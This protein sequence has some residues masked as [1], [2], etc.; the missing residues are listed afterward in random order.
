MCRSCCIQVEIDLDMWKDYV[1]FARHSIST[2]IHISAMKK[3]AALL[4][5]FLTVSLAAMAQIM[6]PVKWTSAIKLANDGASGTVTLTATIDPGWHVYAMDV[7]P[8]VGVTPLSVSLSKE[9]GIK[10]TGGWK[11]SKSP[12]THFDSQFEADLRWWEHGVSLTRKFKVTGADVVIDGVVRYHTC[13]DQMCLPPSKEEFALKAKGS[14]TAASESAEPETDAELT[15]DT[16]K[17]ITDSITTTA[18]ATDSLSEA[19]SGIWAPVEFT[20]QNNPDDMGTSS[21]WYVFAMCFLGGLVALI[22]PCVWPMIPLTVSFFLKRGDSKAKAIGDAITYG[23]SIVVIYVI[24]GLAITLIFGA[25]ALNKMATSAVC[26][27]LFFLLLVVFAISFFGAFDIKLP[28]KWGNK[29]D[30]KAEKTTGLL[31][32]F[33]MAFTLTLVSFSCTGPIIGTLLVETATSGDKLGPAIGMLGFSLALAIPFCLFA[34][35]PSW[36]QTAPRSG[37]WMTTVKVVLGFAELA[38][39]LKFLSVADLAY[40]WHILDRE[41]F[42][43]LWIVMFALCGL[44]LLGVYQF[45]HYGEPDRSPGTVRFFLAM[46]SLSF[47]VYLVPGLWGAP[48]KSVS[49]FVPPL[50]TQDLNLY[51]HDLEEFDNYDQAMAEAAKLGKPV[52]VDFSGYGCVNCRKME[53]AVLDNENVHAMIT[54]NFVVVTLMV[55]D[56]A[57]LPA[58][59]KVVENGKPLTL[60]TYGEKWSYLQRVKFRA[61][62]QPYYV[63]LSP[64]GNLLS[65]PFSYDEN[66]PRF[67]KFLEDGIR[68]YKK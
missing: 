60:E 29:M 58:P 5:A 34:L 26:N 67:T 44:Y 64:D 30:A 46:I 52:F 38:L 62:A 55:D 57:P 8:D 14:G 12:E 54:D 22:T 47:A 63:I 49:A 21:L 59:E 56:R 3:T 2:I 39:S 9:Q 50:Y 31:S 25:D 11:P 41:T 28:E 51:G 61:N 1:N 18:A 35:F 36:L 32:I 66:I 27:I 19:P 48:L 6:T 7:N 13:N 10:W 15:A 43:A 65:G 17:A 45:S 33:F 37:S 4:I 53:G 68:A 23:L 20:E 42:L 16:V 40:G 24:L